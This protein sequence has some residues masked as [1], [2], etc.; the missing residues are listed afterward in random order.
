MQKTNQPTHKSLQPSISCPQ[1]S[2]GDNIQQDFLYIVQAVR[3]SQEIDL[4]T[5]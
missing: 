4:I 2:Y 3:I 1:S 5:N